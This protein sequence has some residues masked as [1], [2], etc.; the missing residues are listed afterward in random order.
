M[1]VDVPL[2]MSSLRECSII[3][4]NLAENTILFLQ[5]LLFSISLLRISFALKFEYSDDK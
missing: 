3:L 5:Y 4:M 2:V 1:L